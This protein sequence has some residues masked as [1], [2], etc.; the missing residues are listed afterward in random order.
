MYKGKS[1]DAMQ[2]IA[3]ASLFSC[4]PKDVEVVFY[5]EKVE[6]LPDNIECDLAAISIDTFNAKRGYEISN[7]LMARGIKTVIGGFHATFLPDETLAF[8]DSVAIGEGE[9][10]WPEIV[11]DFRKNELK[12]KYYSSNDNITSIHFDRTIF[13]GKKYNKIYPIQF[14]RGCRYMCEFCSIHAFFGNSLKCRSIDS[15]V[16][17]IKDINKK[18]FFFVDD[19]LF[20]SEKVVRE[21][22]VKIK[23][24]KVKWICQISIDIAKNDELLSLMGEAGC[25]CVLIGFESL[26]KRNLTQMGKSGNL[27]AN[28]YKNIIDKIHKNGIMV[29]AMFVFGYDF[30]NKESFDECVKFAIENEVLIANFN[31]LIPTPGTRLYDRLESEG[32]LIFDKWWLDDDFKYGDS[33]FYPKALTPQELKDGCYKARMNFYSY[34]SIFKRLFNRDANS[35]NIYMLSVYLLANLIS[36]WEIKAKQGKKLGVHKNMK[37]E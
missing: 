21:L 18:L 1:K 13:K 35:K 8:C 12:K 4:T 19:N 33:A 22:L 37:G 3:F 29:Y 11:E 20:Y 30:D 2:P 24:L 7:D 17:E 32:R 9:F 25:I 16:N 31:P 36:R 10:V 23:P 27:K 14:S 34:K 5:D 15:V 6:R 26:D 28:E